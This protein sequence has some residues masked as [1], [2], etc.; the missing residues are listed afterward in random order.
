MLI[1]RW[2]GGALLLRHCVLPEANSGLC[3]P[4]VALCSTPR[5]LL[6]KS[7][8][9][10]TTQRDRSGFASYT[11]FSWQQPLGRCSCLVPTLCSAVV[12]AASDMGSVV[13]EVASTIASLQD[14]Q[15]LRPTLVK[16]SRVALSSAAVIANRPAF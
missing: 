2:V 1:L 6:C 15:S 9:D 3:E 12:E 5:S 14:D 10:R 13:V 8:L 4:D 11:V 16:T 7:R